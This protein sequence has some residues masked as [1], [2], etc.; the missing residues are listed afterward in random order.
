MLFWLQKDGKGDGPEVQFGWA[1]YE[2]LTLMEDTSNC[3][4]G[5]APALGLWKS[6]RLSTLLGPLHLPQHSQVTEDQ[7]DLCFQSYSRSL[8]RPWLLWEEARVTLSRDALMEPI[9]ASQKEAKS[10]KPHLRTLLPHS[11]SPQS[12]VFSLSFPISLLLMSPR[13]EPGWCSGLALRI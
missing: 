10:H 6:L 3:R 8:K 13:L 12:W 11:Q 9:S 1:S 7:M 5:R 2:H 4:P